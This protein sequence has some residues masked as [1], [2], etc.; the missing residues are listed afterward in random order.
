MTR[1]EV[2]LGARSY[3]ILIEC[4]GLARAGALLELER[5]SQVVIITEENLAG[6]LTSLQSGL[7]LA[8]RTL[9]FEARG[10]ALKCA[11]EL[12]RIYQFLVDAGVDRQGCV[13]A[14][15]GGVVGDLAGFAA[16]SYLRGIDVIQLPTT[17]LAQVDSAIGGKTGINLPAG[18]NLVG[19]FH[20]PRAV[21]VDPRVLSTLPEREV[22]AGLGEVI[23]YGM[24]AD[25][26]LFEQLASGPL[27]PLP[28]EGTLSRIIADCC[29]IKARVVAADETES[30]DATLSRR[31]LNFG[32]T[33]AHALEA[34]TGYRH[35]RHGEAVSLG[36]AG[37]VEIS[38]RLGHLAQDSADA[39]LAL[40]DRLPLPAAPADLQPEAVL[41][42]TKNDKKRIGGRVHW[43][44]LRGIGQT[45]ITP[46]VPAETVAESLLE[47]LARYGKIC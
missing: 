31:I 28:D 33:L 41:A 40:L 3:P 10:E 36:I 47:V 32:H 6:H 11:A 27:H 8:C 9:V 46:D 30:P 20:Q 38:R 42:G 22:I 19:A 25:A 15:G 13:L 2:E 16:A 18:K 5:W 21:L 39:C 23:K 26:K 45:L 37:A 24:I 14:F 7:G 44:L 35:Y 43:V 17:L 29:A 12:E 1:V 34:A 4:G